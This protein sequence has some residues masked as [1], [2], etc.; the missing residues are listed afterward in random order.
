MDDVI[1]KKLQK[2]NEVFN[3]IEFLDKPV[4]AAWKEMYA[5]AATR[6]QWPAT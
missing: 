6:W 4:I 5:A 1:G 2:E 3:A